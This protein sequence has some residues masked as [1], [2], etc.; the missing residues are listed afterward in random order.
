MRKIMALLAAVLLVVCFSFSVSAATGVSSMET[1]GTVSPDGQCQISLN[2]TFHL[3]QPV[4]KLTF[5]IPAA[6]S[7]VSLNGS[8]VGTSKDGDARLV[9]LSK[10]TKNVV[11]DVTVNI[12]YTLSDVISTDSEGMLVMQLPL[13]SGFE[14][15]VESMKFSVNLPGQVQSLPGFVSGYHQA[16]IEEHLSYTVDGA[17]ISGFSLNPMKDH[18]TLY[19][20]LPVTEEMFP[21]TI[22]RTQDHNVVLTPMWILVAVA[23]LY[24]IVW[25]W[26]LPV[27]PVSTS[28]PPHGFHA[29]QLGTVTAGQGMDLSMTV[30]HWAQLGY[31]HIRRDRNRILLQKRMDMGNERSEAEQRC[32]RK[33]FAVRTT[34]DTSGTYYASLCRSA[35]KRKDGM[36]GL[37]K[38]FNGNPKI[39]RAIIS[40]CCALM[41]AGMAVAMADGA[42]LQG[43]LIAL[44]GILGGVSGWFMQA[45][46]GKVLLGQWRKCYPGVLLYGVWLV[47]SLLSGAVG[48]GLWML[49]ISF[50]GGI[51]LAWGGRRNLYGRQILKQTVGIGVYFRTADKQQLQQISQVDPDYFFSMLPYAMALG[52]DKA[53]AKRLGRMRL[54][55]C[56]YASV[57]N[58]DSLT[59]TQ[60]V[61]QLRKVRQT[62]DGRASHLPLEKAV[63]MVQSLLRR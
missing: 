45:L 59:P 29:G 6:A 42:A 19:M 7:A 3:E 4:E 38:K 37:M 41:G 54:Q 9:N 27:W 52:Q 13:L 34:V 8:R 23:A 5:P 44:L 21:Q 63:A 30:I 57:N 28:T 56:P 39:F 15:P 36:A 17:G 11:G 25:M 33:L 12:H 24:W 18:E 47:V 14:Y 51:L 16:R 10:V 60:W 2:V 22:I 43:L 50:L 46:S 26:N 53:F 61:M 20:T 31:L 32:F 40:L 48:L 55:S 62:M 35:E 1:N 58:A 49:A